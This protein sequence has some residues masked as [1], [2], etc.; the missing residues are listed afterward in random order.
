MSFILDC[1]QSSSLTQT[2]REKD[3]VRVYEQISL[4]ATK[5]HPPLPNQTNVSLKL[6]LGVLNLNCLLLNLNLS[7]LV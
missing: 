6:S 3:L 4:A 7:F 2:Q 5:R 1:L